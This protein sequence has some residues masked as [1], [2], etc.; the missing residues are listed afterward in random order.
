MTARADTR[1]RSAAITHK[2]ISMIFNHSHLGL[3]FPAGKSF[4]VRRTHG[5]FHE[6][7]EKTRRGEPGW[8]CDGCRAFRRA[9][10][11]GRRRRAGRGHGRDR[12]GRPARRTIFEG[13]F[14]P[15]AH[16]TSAFRRPSMNTRSLS[17][18]VRAEYSSGFIL[19]PAA[20]I[21]VPSEP[22]ISVSSFTVGSNSLVV[23][24]LAGAM[25]ATGSGS[26][27]RS[28]ARLAA[29]SSS[30]SSCPGILAGFRAG[31]R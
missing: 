2:A 7:Q 8:G 21:S 26:S 5:Y 19:V 13:R 3:P 23:R 24:F 27:I 1:T 4:P 25:P 15:R 30:R 31:R 28:I 16:S 6:T 29:F 11:P 22:K 10:P 9:G 18:P 14:R 17:S 20:A 12:A